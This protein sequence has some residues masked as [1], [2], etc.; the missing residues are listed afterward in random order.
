MEIPKCEANSS[1]STTRYCVLSEAIDKLLF[2]S[3]TGIYLR[4]IIRCCQTKRIRRSHYRADVCGPRACRGARTATPTQLRQVLIITSYQGL[5][6]RS[7]P[8]LNLLFTRECLI[9]TIEILPIH[10]FDWKVFPSIVRTATF[11]MLYQSSFHIISATR[12]IG[13]IGTTK[14]VH[15]CHNPNDSLSMPV[16]LKHFAPL[17]KLGDRKCYSPS[18]DNIQYLCR[19]P[20]PGP[21]SH[22]PAPM[23]PAPSIP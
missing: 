3:I 15:A 21:E 20:S 1:I 22:P 16:G 19:S 6:L 5:F 17:D 4:S 14:N 7:R 2:F 18:S 23:P 12:V 13:V 11:R 9:Y 10:K 8:I